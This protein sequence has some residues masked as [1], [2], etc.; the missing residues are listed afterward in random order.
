MWIFLSCNTDYG[1][2]VTTSMDMNDNKAINYL[3]CIRAIG[4]VCCCLRYPGDCGI[5]MH[6]HTHTHAVL[7]KRQCHY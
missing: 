4:F 7:M 3:F 1:A 6:T 5:H 2:S